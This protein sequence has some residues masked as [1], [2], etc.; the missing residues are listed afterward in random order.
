MILIFKFLYAGK[1]S[2]P[3][4]GNEN[5]NRLHRL[6][7][8]DRILFKRNNVFTENVTVFNCKAGLSLFV[9]DV[10]EPFFSLCFFPPW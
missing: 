10:P 2:V 3:F 6:M 9:S 8:Y 4:Y 1:G 7:Y 5:H